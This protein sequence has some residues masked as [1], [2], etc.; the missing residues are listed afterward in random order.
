MEKMFF[1][2]GMAG[3]VAGF[4]VMLYQGIMFLKIDSW[5][6]YTAFGVIEGSSLGE[7]V[8]AYP[9]L[10]N[11]LQKF[12]LSAALMG[13]GFILLWVASRIRARYS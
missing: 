3:V 10:M 4:A 9:G 8:T 1:F 7:F 6:P 13:I 2:G 11:A 12:P 5:L